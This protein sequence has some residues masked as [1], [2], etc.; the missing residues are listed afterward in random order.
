MHSLGLI[1]ESDVGPRPGED[2]RRKYY[3]ITD[4]GR[5]TARAEARRLERVLAVAEEKSLVPRPAGGVER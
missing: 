1:T 5:E 3:A 4:F 2:Q